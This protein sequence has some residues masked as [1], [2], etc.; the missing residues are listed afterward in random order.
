ML[1]VASGGRGFVH[2]INDYDRFRIDVRQAPHSA[3]IIWEP[4]QYASVM[5]HV[6]EGAHV[7]DVGAFV[8]L[9]ALGAAIR[10]GSTGRIVAIEA[11]PRSARRLRANVRAN[12]FNN[13]I[14]VVEAVCADRVGDT[15]VFFASEGGGMTDSAV[16]SAGV[17]TTLRLQTTTVDSLVADLSLRPSVIKIDVEGFEDLVLKGCV[18]TLRRFRPVVFMECHPDMLAKR[19]VVVGEVVK[20]LADCGLGCDDSRLN[21]GTHLSSGA[22]LTFRPV[23]A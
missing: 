7:I 5:A 23:R 21:D 14:H 11:S 22:M 10:V 19:G 13:V 16:G 17:A 3:P 4:E 20:T 9:Y 18:E 15:V 6:R 12:R 1:W 2:T 8:G